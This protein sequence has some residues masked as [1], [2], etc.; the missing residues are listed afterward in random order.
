MKIWIDQKKP[1]ERQELFS[2]EHN[3]VLS[4]LRFE[5]EIRILPLNLIFSNNI[6][7]FLKQKTGHKRGQKPCSSEI[8]KDLL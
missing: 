2:V 6:T 4:F 1:R 3:L 8:R 7:E 5:N